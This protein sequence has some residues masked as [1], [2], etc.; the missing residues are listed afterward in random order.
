MLF[1]R[2]TI[3]SGH[4]GSGK[5]NI[6][7]NLSLDLKRQESNVAIADVDI[8][9]PYFRTKDS[10]DLLNEKGIKLICS[11]F[12]N[13]NVDL[14]SLPQELYAITDDKSLHVILDVGGDDRGALALG[15]LAPK[16]EEENNFDMYY[17]I[18]KFRPL[19]KDAQ[20]TIEVMKE[21]EFACKLKFT[22]IINN[23]NLGNETTC[24]DVIGSLAYANEISQITSLPIIMTTVKEEL[25]QTLKDKIANLYPLKLQKKL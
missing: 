10:E 8:V 14:P 11:A 18:N 1:K 23:S 20:S 6:A 12:A 2:V 21:I 17:V 13:S 9:N 25:Y 24:E 7:V 3:I 19:T 16:L 4:F 15:R 5:T 22:G